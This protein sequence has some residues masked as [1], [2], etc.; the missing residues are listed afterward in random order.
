MAP[1]ALLAFLIFAFISLQISTSAAVWLPRLVNFSP[2]I[3]FCNYPVHPFLSQYSSVLIW[4]Y[5]FLTIISTFDFGGGGGNGK[6]KKKILLVMKIYLGCFPSAHWRKV[7]II[8]TKRIETEKL[9][10]SRS[11]WKFTA[12]NTLG[13]RYV[14][15]YPVRCWRRGTKQTSLCLCSTSRF[16]GLSYALIPW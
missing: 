9:F 2:F 16:K 5:L 7:K 12:K 11:I 14:H 10:S 3:H 4:Q 6:K 8:S 13:S 15:L 1:H